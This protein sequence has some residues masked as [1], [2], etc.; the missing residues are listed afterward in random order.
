MLA[1]VAFITYHSTRG[2]TDGADWVNQR[3][4]F[5]DQ[6]SGFDLHLVEVDSAVRG[7]LLASDEQ[8]L[9]AYEKGLQTL[10]AESR[11]IED[12]VNSGGF[13]KQ[14]T[15]DLETDLVGRIPEL[16]SKKT[17]ILKDAVTARQSM[18]LE[19][20]A[21]KLSDGQ[22]ENVT[23]EL[24]SILTKLRVSEG[25]R[26]KTRSDLSAQIGRSSVAV[27]VMATL[28]SAVIL[29]MATLLILRDIAV[30]RR[31]EEAM[32]EEHNLLRSVMDAM[33]EQVFVTDRKGQFIIDNISHRKFIGVKLANEVE[34]KSSADFP[35][36]GGGKDAEGRFRDH[37]DRGAGAEPGGPGG[38][39]RGG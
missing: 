27:V 39:R 8:Y 10:F 19:G 23:K 26:L 24:R 1:T 29:T 9:P 21:R 38:A 31:A 2:L 33:P 36:S 25:L 32:A 14:E 22:D 13:E 11:S 4:A 3:Q 12:A 35:R 34:G 28:L 30:R 17:A 20:A 6:L 16:L 37:G 7:Y 15:H 18:G 5:L